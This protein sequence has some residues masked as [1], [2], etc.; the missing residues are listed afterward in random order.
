MENREDRQEKIENIRER[1]VWRRGEN[2]MAPKEK[3]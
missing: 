2:S 3:Y 1:K